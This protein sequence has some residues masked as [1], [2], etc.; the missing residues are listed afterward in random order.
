MD[1]IA[2]RSTL[3]M[4]VVVVVMDMDSRDHWVDIGCRTV[5]GVVEGRLRH[6]R[7]HSKDRRVSI[8]NKD[9][10]TDVSVEKPPSAAQAYREDHREGQGSGNN[11]KVQRVFVAHV[12]SQ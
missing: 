3:D 2:G 1:T 9:N 11:R 7:T 8:V 5:M 10:E 6:M 12:Q 4:E